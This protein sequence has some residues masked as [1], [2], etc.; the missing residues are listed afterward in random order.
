MGGLVKRLSRGWLPYRPPSMQLRTPSPSLR[1]SLR[2]AGWWRKSFI[3]LRRR[4]PARTSPAL[5]RRPLMSKWLTRKNTVTQ[6]PLASIWKPIPR[7]TLCWPAVEIP[8]PQRRKRSSRVEHPNLRIQHM[9]LTAPG[10]RPPWSQE[11]WLSYVLHPQATLGLRRG[12]PHNRSLPSPTYP[13]VLCL[14]PPLPQKKEVGMVVR[15]GK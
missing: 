7:T 4:R 12:R 5:E 15:R 1:T 6:S 10:V 3:R 2:I 13:E 11:G 9:D 14:S 8:F